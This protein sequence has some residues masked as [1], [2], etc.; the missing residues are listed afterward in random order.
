MKLMLQPLWAHPLPP[1]ALAVLMRWRIS[2]AVAESV[3]AATFC[4]AA[5]PSAAARACSLG[6]LGCCR[7]IAHHLTV[8]SLSPDV[9]APLLLI[10]RAIYAS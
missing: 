7:H 8:A 3:A 2:S 9:A 5:A 1:P 4:D 10:L 6:V